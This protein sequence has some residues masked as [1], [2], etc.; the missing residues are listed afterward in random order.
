[1]I[2]QALEKW[3]DLGFASSEGKTSGDDEKDG[4]DAVKGGSV[5]DD[6]DVADSIKRFC[7]QGILLPIILLNSGMI[8][9]LTSHTA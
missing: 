8:D 4:S 9:M 6:E 5:S 2:D 3:K 7:E 1:M